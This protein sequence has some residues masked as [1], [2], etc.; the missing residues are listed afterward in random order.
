[1]KFVFSNRHRFIALIPTIGYWTPYGFG[2]I[3]SAICVRFLNYSVGLE[4]RIKEEKV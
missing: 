3:K 4:F 1:M 2:G